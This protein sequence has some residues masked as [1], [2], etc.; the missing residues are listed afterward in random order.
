MKV[1]SV[2]STAWIL[3]TNAN[4]A[5][6]VEVL[7]KLANSGFERAW[8]PP[9]M[10]GSDHEIY[11]VCK[12]I[13]D[14]C[15][16]CIDIEESLRFTKLGPEFIDVLPAMVGVLEPVMETIFGID[17]WIFAVFS[18]EKPQGQYELRLKFELAE[19]WAERVIAA[20]KKGAMASSTT[21]TSG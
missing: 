4:I 8:G 6:Q 14:A 3:E 21:A 17:T 15:S 11:A 18:E 10:P 13:R 5:N 19:G 12:L 7:G 9:G 2:G 1:S 20:M 16:R